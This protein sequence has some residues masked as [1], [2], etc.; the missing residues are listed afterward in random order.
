[1][2]VGKRISKLRKNLKLTQDDLAKIIN[3]HIASIKK[4][5]AD[6]MKPK[7]EHL[8]KIASVLNVRPYVISENVF[9]LKLETIG[10][11]YSIVIFMYNSEFISFHIGRESN[12]IDIDINPLVSDLLDLNLKGD[13]DIPITKERLAISINE[14]LKKTPTYDIFLQWVEQCN[15]LNSFINS[16]SNPNNPVAINTIKEFKEEIEILELKL[17]QSTELLK[18]LK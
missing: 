6:K 11:L 8:E 9:E 17:Q 4:Y 1:M 15:S 12:N 18:D 3:V 13:V 7:K 14:T 5:E 2:T 16:L 10:D